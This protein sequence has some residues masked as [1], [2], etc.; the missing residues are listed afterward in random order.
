MPN[1]VAFL[2]GINV[3]GNKKVAMAQLREL[4]TEHG[5]TNVRTLLNSGNVVFA[6]RKKAATL[7]T[8]IEQ[9]IADGFG[10]SV[11]CLVRS[12]AEIRSVI[13]ANPLAD[14]A[15]NGSRYLV[16]FLSEP[17][18]KALLEANDPRGLAPDDVLLGDRVIYQWCPNG[19]MEAPGVG[20]FVEKNF[21]VSIT[22]RNWNTVEKLAAM[23]DA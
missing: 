7:E 15:D 17:L 11:R 9:I 5:L 22:G 1:Y 12:E 14:K 10:I 6:S 21:K 3:G 20:G 13:K 8:S 4:L 19:I 2:R 18:D 23:L 16:L